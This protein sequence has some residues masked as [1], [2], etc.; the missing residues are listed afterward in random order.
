MHKRVAPPTLPG[1]PEDSLKR[2]AGGLLKPRARG[3]GGP[4]VRR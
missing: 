3:L 4:G 2:P 1:L